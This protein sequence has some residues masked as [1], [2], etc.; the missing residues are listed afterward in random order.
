MKIIIFVAVLLLTGCVA[1]KDEAQSSV[2]PGRMKLISTQ[3]DWADTWEE[4]QD[5]KTGKTILCHHSGDAR[6][7]GGRSTSCMVVE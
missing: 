7:S 3:G 2:E 4:W 1:I 6:I 5:T